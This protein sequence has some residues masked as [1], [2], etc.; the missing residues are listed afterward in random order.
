MAQILCFGA[1]SLYGV[2][3]KEGGWPDYLK[4]DIHRTQFANAGRGERDEVY[5]F[6][7]PGVT[8]EFVIKNLDAF[9]SLY[10]RSE[11]PT[12]LVFNVGG[13]DSRAYQS[14]EAYVCT[15]EEFEAKIQT[16]LKKAQTYS[17]HVMILGQNQVN[18]AVV[19]PKKNPWDGSVS[20]FYNERRKL[21]E[22]ITAKVAQS[23]GV[24]FIPLHELG[25]GVD[26]QEFIYIDG[27]H[28]NTAGHK[29]IYNQVKPHITQV[30]ERL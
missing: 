15:P 21:F 20:Y 4:R 11:A 14:P 12:I 5:N 30:L 23:I 22:E 27:L 16:M 13:N 28:P 8:T 25:S 3:G 7:K 17:K 26:P 9:V 1:S 29:W 19:N 24:I 18:E 2:G 10:G 6:G